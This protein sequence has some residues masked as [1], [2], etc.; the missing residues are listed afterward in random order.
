MIF[1][2]QERVFVPLVLLISVSAILPA[3]QTLATFEASETVGYRACL[4]L[5]QRITDCL[6]QVCDLSLASASIHKQNSTSNVSPI[7]GALGPQ[8]RQ[9]MA[10]DEQLDDDESGSSWENID[11]QLY[12]DSEPLPSTK[13]MNWQA[14]RSNT[15][16]SSS[17]TTTTTM[18]SKVIT[19]NVQPV[20]VDS[21]WLEQVSLLR[22]QLIELRRRLDNGAGLAESL[23]TLAHLQ[24]QLIQ[25]NALPEDE[26]EADYI[27]QVLQ[28]MGE[29][30]EDFERRVRLG[31]K[32]RQPESEDR[33]QPKTSGND[34]ANL[35]TNKLLPDD[36]QA[37]CDTLKKHYAYLTQVIAT[38]ELMFH[39]AK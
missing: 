9:M 35:A 29:L 38:Y 10:D 34:A 31:T 25:A 13:P 26:L 17:S 14:N 24:R 12:D 28:V 2:H 21:R 6:I 33:A 20:S 1:V 23:R 18:T 22:G 32:L 8:E 4:H 36:E 27:S 30:E 7:A 15:T 37:A 39:L 19:E 16:S 3:P 5:L 11:F